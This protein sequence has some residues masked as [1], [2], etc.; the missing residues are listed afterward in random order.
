MRRIPRNRFNAET[1]V[2]EFFNHS[3]RREWLDE[4]LSVLQKITQISEVSARFGKRLNLSG[5]NCYELFRIVKIL[6]TFRLF[7]RR[8]G[9]L[10]AEIR[11]P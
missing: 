9:L 2:N 11:T 3:Q 1:L 7:D 5:S 4:V 8:I 6:L 10:R